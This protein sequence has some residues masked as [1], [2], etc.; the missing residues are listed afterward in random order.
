MSIGTFFKLLFIAVLFVGLPAEAADLK[1]ISNS[2][3]LGIGQRFTVDVSVNTADTPINAAQAVISFP[4]NILEVVDIGLSGSVFRFWVELPEVSNANGTVTFVGGTSSGVSGESAHLLTIEFKTKGVGSGTI[5]GQDVVIAA[6]DGLGTNVFNDVIP[7][8]IQVGSSVVPSVPISG[9]QT[10]TFVESPQAVTRTAVQSSKLPKEPVLRVSLYPEPEDW[11]NYQG[12]LIA[13]WDVPNDITKVAV[14]VDKQPNTVPDD[15]EDSL[16]TGKN[17]GILDE[18]VWYVH[19]QFRNNIGWGAVAHQRVAIDITPPIAFNI[20]IDNDKSD[21][22][23]PSIS[24]DTQDSLSGLFNTKIYVDG[25]EVLR[26]TSTVAVLPVQPPGKHKLLVRAYDEAGNSSE[27]EIQFEIIP[28]PTPIIEFVTQSASQE[29]PIYISG[30]SIQNG[31]VEIAMY[32]DKGQ[33]VYSGGV[34]TDG[35]GKWNVAIEESLAGGSYAI[36]VEAKDIRGARSFAQEIQDIK[37]KP[38]TII[39]LGVVELDWFEIF[40]IT[41]L[42]AAVGTGIFSWY[43]FNVQR[44]RHAYTSVVGQDIE[45]L[46]KMMKVDLDNL[47]SHMTDPYKRNSSNAETEIAYLFKKARKTLRDIK[48]YISKEIEKLR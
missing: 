10:S 15:I 20:K 46:T 39:S 18:G 32:N 36:S 12:E 29:E 31:F 30:E 17:L 14:A 25:N 42:L 47:E 45:K 8:N 35:F 13:L 5:I 22:P 23:T 19:T 21:N 40:I 26:S 37:V 34:E 9:G 3:S 28:L 43:V 48:K 1:I 24:F 4:N 2:G 38:R 41:L 7:A 16:F 44:K 33:E 6:S 27:D 11:Y